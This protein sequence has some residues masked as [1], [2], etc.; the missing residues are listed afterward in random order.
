M[1]ASMDLDLIGRNQTVGFHTRSECIEKSSIPLPDPV[2]WWACS[3]D[4][5]DQLKQ[6]SNGVDVAVPGRVHAVSKPLMLV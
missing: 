4:F 1:G 5:L 2:G 3:G 6:L